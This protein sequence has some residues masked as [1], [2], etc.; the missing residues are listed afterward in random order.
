MQDSIPQILERRRARRFCRKLTL[1][2]ETSDASGEI[3]RSGRLPSHEGLFPVRRIFEQRDEALGSVGS[4]CSGSQ[5]QRFG[6]SRREERDERRLPSE[7]R[8]RFSTTEQGGGLSV[9]IR[10]SSLRM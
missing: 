6:R 1:L 2:G 10:T 5:E 3:L 7:Q 9:R 8:R 4:S